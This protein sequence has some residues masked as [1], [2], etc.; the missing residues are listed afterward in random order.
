MVFKKEEVSGNGKGSTDQVSRLSDKRDINKIDRNEQLPLKS[1]AGREV[2]RGDPD[3]GW[4]ERGK[5]K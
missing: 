4:R 2:P 1:A 5:G 3:L